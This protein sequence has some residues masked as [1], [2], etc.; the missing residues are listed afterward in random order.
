MPGCFRVAL[1]GKTGS[2][3]APLF[4][5]PLLPVA[6]RQGYVREGRLDKLAGLF[7]C[8]YLLPSLKTSSQRQVDYLLSFFVYS[9]QAFP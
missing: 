1:R 6:V 8:G 3:P 5:V 7:L 9:P 2:V 4:C